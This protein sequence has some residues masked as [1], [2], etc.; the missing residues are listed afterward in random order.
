MYVVKNNI[1]HP[2][3]VFENIVFII[4]SLLFGSCTIFAFLAGSFV[5][6]LEFMLF[7]LFG[8]IL[9]YQNN[10]AVAYVYDE[11]V[12][13]RKFFKKYT[14]QFQNI[15]SVTHNVRR[16]KYELVFSGKK[17]SIP[18]YYRE[19]KTFV[20]SLEMVHNYFATEEGIERLKNYIKE[21][22][23]AETFLLLPKKDSEPELL[24][25]KIGGIPYWDLS[26]E[27]PVDTAGKKMQLLCQ[28]NFSECTYEN[29][30]FPKEGILQFFISSDDLYG[31]SFDEPSVQTN[32]R[33]IF[34]E[35]IDKNVCLKDIQ[36]II[37][38][39]AEISNTPILNSAALVF[40]RSV[41]YMQTDDYRM[42]TV[43][44]EA[45]RN[46]TGED[47]DKN[48]YEVLGETNIHAHAL[49]DMLTETENYVLGYPS[50]V[51]NDIREY[52]T[53]EDAAYYDTNLLH[54]TSSSCGGQVLCWGDTGEATFLINSD[55]LKKRDFSK[56]VYTWDCF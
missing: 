44:A 35:K 20:L 18:D 14:Y 22:A 3:T 46:I 28:L 10:A 27:Y 4:N 21:N 42:N 34:H 51:Q 17:Y 13:I 6:T 25:S 39:T 29:P 47:T 37:P 16:G 50:F 8:L 30:L 52:M 54:L 36:R 11:K 15:E 23:S 32:W 9:L 7:F 45:V 43:I 24:S 1:H 33:I 55:A 40:T 31:M 19:V 41:S 48:I 38:P 12:V 49:Y 56:V 26:L 53:A 2:A 5:P